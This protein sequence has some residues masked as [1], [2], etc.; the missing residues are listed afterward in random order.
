MASLKWV[1]ALSCALAACA[2]GNGRIGAG[3]DTLD[4][5]ADAYG[6]GALGFSCYPALYVGGPGDPQ[7]ERLRH[8][9]RE[10]RLRIRAVLVAEFGAERVDEIERVSDEQEHG[11]YRTGCDLDE[12][13]RARL[14]YRRF[15]H[16][17]EI[18]ARLR[19]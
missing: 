17:L 16:A 1:V 10:R 18:R 11:V 7:Y 13:A 4:L 9:L 3:V 8:T 12:T 19:R 2:S 6:W 15:L 14:K 5:Y